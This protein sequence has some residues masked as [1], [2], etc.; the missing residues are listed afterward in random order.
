MSDEDE[1]TTSAPKNWFEYSYFAYYVCAP[2]TKRLNIPIKYS[3]A[4]EAA[5]HLIQ[6][7]D[8][9]TSGVDVSMLFLIVALPFWLLPF[10]Y[11]KNSF[12]P[13]LYLSVYLY[14]SICA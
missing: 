4:D 2:S 14:L 6:R 5:R 7:F 8:S 9:R 11:V 3:F 1:W 12:Y 10:A 13:Y